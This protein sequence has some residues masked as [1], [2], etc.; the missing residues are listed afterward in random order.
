MER[1]TSPRGLNLPVVPAALVVSMDVRLVGGVETLEVVGRLMIAAVGRV[2]AVVAIAGIE[3]AIDAAVEAGAAVIP[4]ACADEDAAIEPF[5]AVVA[6]GSA[7]VG[8]ES[9]VSVGADGSAS[10]DADADRNL[11]LG[12]LRLWNES[13][14]DDGR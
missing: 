2:S 11:G 6:V 8:A 9:V 10:T 7:V 4:A 14:E 5:G 3:A 13:K 1:C 12:G